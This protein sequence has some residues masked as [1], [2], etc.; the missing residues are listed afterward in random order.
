MCRWRQKGCLSLHIQVGVQ[1]EEQERAPG[2]RAASSQ[3][4]HGSEFL[5]PL[6]CS[7]GR[8]SARPTHTRGQGSHVGTRYRP[9]ASRGGDSGPH[10]PAS[11][12]TLAA[13]GA[14]SSSRKRCSGGASW[15]R[16]GLVA[17]S[18]KALHLP[19]R[20]AVP[21]RD[22]PSGAWGPCARPGVLSCLCQA[23]CPPAAPSAEG[24]S[25]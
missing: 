23:R 20:G 14:T 12:C 13:A 21:G 4:E 11:L 15:S 25:G 10:F 17:D 16:A 7:A 8:E 18:G 3:P 24:P 6:P 9:I 5:W 2:P 22:A 1:E 19:R